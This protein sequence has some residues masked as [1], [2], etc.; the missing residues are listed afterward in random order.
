MLTSLKSMI[1]SQ[2]IMPIK[3][4]LCVG[5]ECSQIETI[6]QFNLLDGWKR[7]TQLEM[8]NQIC[9]LLVITMTD[10]AYAPYHC[11]C[12][13]PFWNKD[14]FYNHLK[15]CDEALEFLKVTKQ[16]FNHYRKLS[17]YLHNPE[18]FI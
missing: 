9:Y 12:K 1:Q 15:D 7:N 13:A 14:D 6:K 4:A 18:E 8:T 11:A 16:I 10:S 3:Y 5:S 2:Y 17:K